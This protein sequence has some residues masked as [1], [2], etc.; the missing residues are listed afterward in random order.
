MEAL[1]APRMLD[2]SGC[3]E[4]RAAEREYVLEFLRLHAAILQVGAG[5][6]LLQVLTFRRPS[7]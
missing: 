2:L 4:Y 7:H 3:L 6:L 5:G 1:D